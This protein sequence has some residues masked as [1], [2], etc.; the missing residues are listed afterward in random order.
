MNPEMKE[1]QS[2]RSRTQQRMSFRNWRMDWLFAAAFCLTGHVA[3][4]QSYLTSTGMPSF[5]APQPVK[6]GF[7][8]AASGN[9]HLSFT[10]GSYPQRGNSQPQTI[11]LEYD[12]SFWAP[13]AYGGTA[14]WSTQNGPGQLV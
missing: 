13:K 12:S 4:S 6:F 3:S 8:D 9:L 5:S 2:Q 11:S 10:L 7:V 1:A 14:Q